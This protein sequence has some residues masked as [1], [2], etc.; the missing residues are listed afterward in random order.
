MYTTPTSRYEVERIIGTLKNKNSSG[1]DEVSNKILKG[2]T[3]GISTPLSILINK[4]LSEGIFPTEMKKAD[5]IPLYKN[6]DKHDKN[7]YRPIS[8]LLTISKVLEKVMYK[9]TYN[10]L[11]NSGQFFKSQYGF[12]TGHS[13]QEA[14]AEL[15]GEIVR[16]NDMG[17]HTIGG[18]P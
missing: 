13:C 8:L 10:F 1:F 3:T 16:N 15:I 7:N 11:N 18:L 17:C 5:T 4:S 9:R 12:R 14:I 2:I 6:K